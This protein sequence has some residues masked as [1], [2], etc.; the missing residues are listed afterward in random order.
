MLNRPTRSRATLALALTL[1]L[2]A[3]QPARAYSVLSHEQVV[4][5]AWKTHIV[6]LLRRRYPGIT[7]EQIKQAH[8]YAYGGAIIQDLGYYPFG[9]KL[10]SDMTH[11]IRTGEFVDNL[12]REAQNPDEYA[13]ALGALAHYISDSLGHPAVNRATASEYPRLRRRYGPVVVYDQDPR[14]HLQ[15]E[16]GF[17][18]LEVVQ[19]RYALEAFHDF[20][21]FA[22]AKPVLERAFQDTYGIPLNQVLTNED[23][24]IGTYRKTVSVLLPKMTQVAV[25]DYGK[26]MR[27]AEPTFVPKKLIYRESKADYQKRFGNSYQRPGFG[28]RVLAFLLKLIPKVGPLKDLALRVPSAD[29]QKTFLSG[30]DTVVDHYHQSIDQLRAEPAD[31]PSLQLPAINLDTGQPASPGSYPLADQT[32]ARYL[33]LLVKPRVAA[34]PPPPSAPWPG[35][36]PA[37]DARPASPAPP[38]PAAP[39]KPQTAPPAA[40]QPEARP[41]LQP[42]DPA[43]RANI[44][45]FFANSQRRGAVLQLKKNQ[46][47]ALP[48]NLQTLRQ[49]PEASSATDAP[50]PQS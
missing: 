25:A 1:L 42:I 41:T 32:Y 39:T 28:T 19:Q 14:A 31:R 22:V 38:A 24:A 36:Q 9:S 26:Q 12:V 50:S 17:D 35:P 27:Q 23:L 4:D 11:Y 46:W 8:A 21:G 2:V 34:P 29:A 37:D 16:F 43:I 44:E 6:P 49:L 40:A 18:V 20:I 48:R 13:F 33:A 30:M 5:L 15:T 3:P 47:K 7:P 10:F 45:H